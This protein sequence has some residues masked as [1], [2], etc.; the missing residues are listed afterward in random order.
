MAYRFKKYCASVPT[1][2]SYTI[3]E[4]GPKRFKRGRSIKLRRFQNMLRSGN[5]CRFRVSF[6]SFDEVFSGDEA[7][8]DSGLV[9]WLRRLPSR[10][11]LRSRRTESTL[12]LLLMIRPRLAEDLGSPG[13]LLSRVVVGLFVFR[14]WRSKGQMLSRFL[15]R[16]TACRTPF[17]TSSSPRKTSTTTKTACR[18]ITVPKIVVFV[19]RS[20]YFYHVFALTSTLRAFRASSLT[21]R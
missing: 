2:V 19:S 11:I 21:K 12:Y 15:W 13:L 17:T 18:R 7:V 3:L 16:I 14:E 9:W 10:F 1:I 20:S 5:G 8:V 4:L 6:S